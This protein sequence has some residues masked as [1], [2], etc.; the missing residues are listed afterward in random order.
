MEFLL[1]KKKKK[2]SLW[3]RE[4]QY[5]NA[6]LTNTVFPSTGFIQVT[7]FRPMMRVKVK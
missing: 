2:N 1:V 5:H 3:K 7:I 6:M 4:M